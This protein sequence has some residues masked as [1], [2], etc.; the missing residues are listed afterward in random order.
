MM[1]RQALK[2]LTFSLS[3]GFECTFK[4]AQLVFQRQLHANVHIA[5]MQPPR[6]KVTWIFTC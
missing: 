2:M 1:D 4:A 6:V 3:E 5:A